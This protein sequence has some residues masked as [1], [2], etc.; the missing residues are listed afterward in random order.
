MIT[1]GMVS[2]LFLLITSFTPNINDMQVFEDFFTET[3]VRIDQFLFIL[4]IFFSCLYAMFSF[5]TLN[6]IINTKD[7]MSRKKWLNFKLIVLIY[8]V[9]VYLFYVLILC[10][11]G[12]LVKLNM[13]LESNYLHSLLILPY[14]ISVLN[15]LFV[16]TFYY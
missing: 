6:I 7:E 1:F 15:S 12:D 8:L 16:F 5:C 14:L 9:I 13:N 2:N 4:Y 3:K 11:K 10:Y